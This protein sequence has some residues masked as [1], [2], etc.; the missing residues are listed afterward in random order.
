MKHIGAT[1][2]E[3]ERLLCRPF[4]WADGRDMLQNWIADPEVQFEYGEPIYTTA[5]EVQI[6][7]QRY[8]ANYGKPDF[9]RWAIIEKAS[10]K[11]IG[12]LAFCRVY[13]DCGTAEIEYCIGKAFWGKGFASEAL[14][15]LIKHTFFHADFVKLEAY[16]RVENIRSG[17][18]LEKSVMHKTDTVERFKRAN[19]LPH[20]EVCYCIER[21]TFLNLINQNTA[22]GGNYVSR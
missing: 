18:V 3:T 1:M 16:H 6:L 12:Q 11:N 13:S 15:G 7:L 5:K 21:E 8:L 14:L 9:C 17:G 22:Q 20:G 2:F 19:T 4:V 10:R